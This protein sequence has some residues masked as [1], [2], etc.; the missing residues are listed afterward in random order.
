[1]LECSRSRVDKLVVFS[2]VDSQNYMASY[3]KQGE[4]VKEGLLFQP[5]FRSRTDGRDVSVF[6]GEK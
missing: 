6:Y 4:L 3:G 2:T 1:M 5:L